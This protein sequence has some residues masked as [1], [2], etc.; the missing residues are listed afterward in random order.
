MKARA[1]ISLVLMFIF[2]GTIFSA[3]NPN[4]SKSTFSNRDIVV[5]NLLNGIN[6]ENVGLISSS[7]YF[8]GELKSSEAVIPLLKILKSDANEELRIMAALSLIKIGDGR[9]VYAVKQQVKFDSS[10]RV[11]KLCQGFY[12]DYLLNKE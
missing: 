11:R 5:E 3:E 10:E 12:N 9:G 1:L 4:K 8:L 6:S 7:A 2:A